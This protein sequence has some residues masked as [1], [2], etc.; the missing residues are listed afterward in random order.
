MRRTGKL[1]GYS[2][3]WHARF[4]DLLKTSKALADRVKDLERDNDRLMDYILK[5]PGDHSSLL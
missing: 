4:A 2:N 3:P 1:K 5:L